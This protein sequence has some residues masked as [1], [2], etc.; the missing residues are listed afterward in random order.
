[1]HEPFMKAGSRG[2]SILGSILLLAVSGSAATAVEPLFPFESMPSQLAASSLAFNEGDAVVPSTAQPVENAKTQ[3][4]SIGATVVDFR[5]QVYNVYYACRQE[6]ND[7]ENIGKLLQTCQPGFLYSIR[8]TDGIISVLPTPGPTGNVACPSNT[9]ARTGSCSNPASPNPVLSCWN[10]QPSAG[11]IWYT[12]SG[13]KPQF[14][15]ECSA[16]EPIDLA[17]SRLTGLQK[18]LDAAPP[19]ERPE[20][21]QTAGVDAATHNTLMNA[22]TNIRSGEE[23][24]A[25]I[26]GEV[27]SFEEQIRAYGDC[28]NPANPCTAELNTLGAQ[29]DDKLQ[30]LRDAEGELETLKNN[31][32]RIA[33]G[34]PPSGG[35]VPSSA[36]TLPSQLDFARNTTGFNG[37]GF[38]GSPET[39]PSSRPVIAS[40]PQTPNPTGDI[41]WAKVCG[42]GSP[43]CQTALSGKATAALPADATSGSYDQARANA[44]YADRLNGLAAEILYK[45]LQENPD[46]KVR[47][48]AAAIVD[49]TKDNIGQQASFLST[50]AETAKNPVLV[51][52]ESGNLP[53]LGNLS[54]VDQQKLHIQ[55]AIIG[56]PECAPGR[57]SIMDCLNAAGLDGSLVSRK[58]VASALGMDC[59]KIGDAAPNICMFKGVQ[60]FNQE[61]V[62]T[63]ASY[64]R[65]VTI[66]PLTGKV[67]SDKVEKIT[68][69][70]QI[71]APSLAAGGTQEQIEAFKKNL[72]KGGI[73]QAGDTVYRTS[74]GTQDVAIKCIDS[75]GGSVPNLACNSTYSAPIKPIALQDTTGPIYRITG[76]YDTAF[77]QV[78]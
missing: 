49:A 76:L 62:L 47:E 10:G 15:G 52:D 27:N 19:E 24:V 11:A 75:S 60:N 72:E 32:V 8:E 44:V 61:G 57:P 30:E 71:I 26:Q 65:V 23:R 53:G 42:R 67:L 22:F 36:D 59:G 40:P 4:D 7:K 31:A 74:S 73:V 18:T 13:E 25:E 66:D 39:Q 1:M 48:E 34:E 29:R 43:N 56:T 17:K 78:L 68:S 20:I 64:N 33:A 5:D 55:E 35:Y 12:M 77:L 45:Q 41:D 28:T 16:G 54:S 21:L 6:T 70:E 37:S 46:E 58:K 38:I 14:S 50:L 3:E 63:N 9:P 2:S 51:T 69:T